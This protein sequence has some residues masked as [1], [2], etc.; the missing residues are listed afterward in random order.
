MRNSIIAPFTDK[1]VE[2]LNIYQSLGFT[3]PFTCGGEHCK[4]DNREDRGVLVATN[5]GWVCPCG[6]YNQNWAHGFMLD[7]ETLKQSF[8]GRVHAKKNSYNE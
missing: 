3:H 4:R 1:Q 8:A 5:D 6:K 2:L 7:T